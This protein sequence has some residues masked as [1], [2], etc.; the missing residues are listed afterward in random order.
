MQKRTRKPKRIVMYEGDVAAAEAV[1]FQ[2]VTGTNRAGKQTTKKIKIAINA[3]GSPSTETPTTGPSQE[4]DDNSFN[5][6]E[7]PDD[8]PIIG[9]KPRKVRLHNEYCP[10]KMI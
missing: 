8:M 9:S 4:I 1:T 5:D 7:M 2:T 10:Q 6:V 3:Q